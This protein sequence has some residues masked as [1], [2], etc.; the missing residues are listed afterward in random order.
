MKDN[1]VTNAREAETSQSFMVRTWQED[2][3]QWR[4]TVRHVQSQVQL[5]FTQVEQVSRFIRQHTTGVEERQSDQT[6]PK[7]ICLSLQSRPESAYNQNA[8]D[9][10]SLDSPFG[11]GD[12]RRK[13]GQSQPG[14]GV[15]ALRSNQ[16]L[17]KGHRERIE[18]AR[19][20]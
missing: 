5:G 12:A 2:P 17:D 1:N 13:T 11:R 10:R 7:A 16:P 4:G 18:S 3:G 14:F 19:Y 6:P 8:G 20:S 9:C 15:R